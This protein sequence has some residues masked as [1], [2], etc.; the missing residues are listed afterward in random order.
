VPQHEEA[1]V[2][3]VKTRRGHDEEADRRDV[4]DVVL[5]KRAPGVRRRLADAAVAQ[6]SDETII[7]GENAA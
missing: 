3:Q 2:E 1:A 6:R 5:E 7:L 4:P